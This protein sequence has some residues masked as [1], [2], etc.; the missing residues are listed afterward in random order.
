ME[1]KNIK[2]KQRDSS[3]NGAAFWPC[4]KVYKYK[5]FCNKLLD[6][7]FCMCIIN[8][9]T[10]NELFVYM[11]YLCASRE[12]CGCIKDWRDICTLYGYGRRIEGN[13]RKTVRR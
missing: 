9:F 5:T 7:L 3:M 13:I 8:L 2:I 4:R 11:I 10:K 6:F 12:E 1:A